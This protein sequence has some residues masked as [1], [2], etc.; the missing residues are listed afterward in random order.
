MAAKGIKLSIKLDLLR[1]QSN[2][3]NITT[4][5]VKWLLSSGR[6][7]FIFV[8]AIVLIAFLTRFKLDADLAEKK[9]SI[10]QKVPFIE[11]LKAYEVAIRQTQQKISSLN[12]FYKESPDYRKIFTEI[13]SRTPQAV[14]ISSLNL[15]K[16]VNRV[17]IQINATSQSN[18]D[19]LGF[20]TALKKAESLSDV[21][22]ASIGLEGNLI[23]ITIT[24]SAATVG[25]KES[26]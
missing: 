16:E 11:S 5:L 18:N 6:Y 15:T 22:L 24:A 17:A 12:S 8:E 14:T 7:I 4:K 19:L 1:P 2:P 13:A 10:E 23:K 9:E 20:I 21:N 25:V 3:Q 26:I